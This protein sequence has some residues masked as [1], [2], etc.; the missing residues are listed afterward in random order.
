MDEATVLFYLAQLC[1]ALKH[2][3]DQHVLHRDLKAAN[4]FIAADGTLRVGDFGISRVLSNTVPN[5]ARVLP[6]RMH[7]ISN[8]P[9]GRAQQEEFAMTAV[10]TPYNLSPEICEGNPYNSKSDCYAL[11]C[12]LYQMLTGKHAYE[13]KSFR[14]LLAKILH[15]AYAP[16]PTSVNPHVR[17][18]VAKLLSRDPHNRPSMDTVLKSPWLRASILQ[19]FGKA[20]PPPP[21]CVAASVRPVILTG[22][23]LPPPPVA[24]PPVACPV[25]LTPA[26]CA[27]VPLPPPCTLPVSRITASSPTSPALNPST[28]LPLVIP[29]TANTKRVRSTISLFPP[30]PPTPPFP[31][32]GVRTPV[33]VST[34]A[35]ALDVD[36]EIVRQHTAKRIASPTFDGVSSYVVI[37]VGC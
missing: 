19:H 27:S 20:L 24:A 31:L 2:L 33:S 12:I 1:M 13:A 30:P 37:Q 18:L 5:T 7:L 21:L 14:D 35:H 23:I 26:N 22:K 29:S 17:E 36:S 10:G 4:V 25:I 15:G 11:G 32:P 8:E 3:H 34:S 28:L 6:L 16:L 9:C